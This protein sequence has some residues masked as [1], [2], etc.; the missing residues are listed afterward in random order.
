MG[1][2]A[3][4]AIVDYCLSFADQGKQT[5]VLHIC[6]QQKNV[7]LPF[8]FSVCSKQMEVAIF[9]EFR[10]LYTYMLTLFQTPNRKRKP[11]R[12]FLFHLQFLHHAI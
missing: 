8:P 10:F 12:F 7:S 4:T 6:L 1:T 11:R 2:F 9:R 3:E 5:G